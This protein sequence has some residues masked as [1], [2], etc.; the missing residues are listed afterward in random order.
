MRQDHIQCNAWKDEVQNLLIF[1]RLH[2]SINTA[3]KCY[4]FSKWKAGLFSAV[5]T[6]FII[7][8]YKTLQPDPTNT[9][10]DLLSQIAIRPD[11]S[12]NSTST[13]PASSVQQFS[14]T[15]S[16]IRVNNFWFISLVLSLTTALIGIISLQWLR[17]HQSYRPNMPSRDKYALFN[18]RSEALKTWHVHTIFTSLPLL[19]QS[20]LILFLGGIIDF[21]STFGHITVLIPVT[22]IVGC[23][24]CFLIGTTALPTLQTMG[25]YFNVPPKLSHSGTKPPSSLLPSQGSYLK[26]V[27]PNQ[28]PYKSPQSW[29]IRALWRT[30]Y[31]MLDRYAPTFTKH[32]PYICYIARMSIHSIWKRVTRPLFRT[33]EPLVSYDDHQNFVRYLSGASAN[34]ESWIDFDMTW[35]AIR[36]QYMQSAFGRSFPPRPGLPNDVNPPFYD[37][38]QGLCWKDGPRAS[39]TAAYRC[40]GEISEWT[41]TYLNNKSLHDVFRHQTVYLCDLLNVSNE[42]LL[43]MFDFDSLFFSER[44]LE[45]SIL[46]S[47][48]QDVYA[49]LNLHNISFFLGILLY[50]SG[51]PG[52]P[53]KDRRWSARHRLEI[54]NRLMRYFF[55]S[56]E[57]PFKNISFSHL[58][59][60]ESVGF[61]VIDMISISVEYRRFEHGEES[62]KGAYPLPFCKTSKSASDTRFLKSTC[63]AARQF[64][65]VG[66]PALR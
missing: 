32:I 40:F 61:D 58:Q 55:D 23:T 9:M 29:A 46:Q 24:L 4:S 57:R 62:F 20:A 48:R 25:L 5:V 41:L 35:L 59:F 7:E 18:M 1:V 56:V 65:T 45:S 26:S 15:A 47:R 66:V 44:C 64:R 38:I 49:V 19:L 22:V 37:I 28:C 51:S 52:W 14:P 34:H 54:K 36:D 30:C 21:L 16:S 53:S 10:I 12:L 11:G 6:T 43:H 31:R 13:L 17:E 2:P 27:P 63:M 42:C 39:S 8:S 3:L 50:R 60:P 33:S